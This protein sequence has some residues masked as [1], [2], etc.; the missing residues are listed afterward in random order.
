MDW[1]REKKAGLQAEKPGCSGPE[2][3]KYAM[4]IYKQLPSATDGKVNGSVSNGDTPKLADTENNDSHQTVSLAHPI[5]YP[6][7]HPFH[8]INVCISICRQR[9]NRS[10][11]IGIERTSLNCKPRNLICRQLNSRN[12]PWAHSNNCFRRPT[13]NRTGASPTGSRLKRGTFWRNGRPW[14]DSR[15]LQS[16][17][18]L[19]LISNNNWRCCGAA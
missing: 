3:T 9:R 11:L 16:W 15:A 19:I 1:Y 6:S 18:N 14:M 13:R 2:L 17:P 5:R 12:S 10:S 4:S 7:L 8:L